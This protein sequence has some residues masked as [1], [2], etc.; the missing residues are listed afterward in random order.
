MYITYIIALCEKALMTAHR[1]SDKWYGFN[2]KWK[3][4]DQQCSVASGVTYSQ[5][6]GIITDHAE[7]RRQNCSLFI[8]AKLRVVVQNMKGNKRRAAEVLLLLWRVPLCSPSPWAK[9]LRD[10]WFGFTALMHQPCRR[11]LLPGGQTLLPS[12]ARLWEA[13]WVSLQSVSL[14]SGG[15]GSSEPPASFSFR[16]QMI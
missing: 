12:A 1:L 15:S 3:C 16:S 13:D 8:D 4:A 9:H 10:N 2:W 7:R 11:P 5:C 6:L 14:A